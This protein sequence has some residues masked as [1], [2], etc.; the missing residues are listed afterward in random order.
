MSRLG[1]DEKTPTVEVNVDA[2]RRRK[3][4]I[5]VPP[6]H[7]IWDPPSDGGV[8]HFQVPVTEPPLCH[9]KVPPLVDAFDPEGE[10]ECGDCK[11]R[12]YP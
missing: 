10:R 6:G 2:Y 11:S 1:D 4:W 5:K 12:W 7:T 3:T 8:E 9:E